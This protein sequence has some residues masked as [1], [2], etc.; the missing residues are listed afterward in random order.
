MVGSIT[1]SIDENGKVGKTSEDHHCHP[2]LQ[3]GAD[4]KA[5]NYKHAGSTSHDR[6]R[7]Q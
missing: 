6:P 1:R 5:S 4:L 2:R 3:E 7:T